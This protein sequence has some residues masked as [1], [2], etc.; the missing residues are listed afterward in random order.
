MGSPT[1]TMGNDVVDT[2]YV[3]DRGG[4]PISE[5]VDGAVAASHR[6]EHVGARH[7]LLRRPAG[8]A[9]HVHV[10]D[11]AHLGGGAPGELDEVRFVVI[12]DNATAKA[13]L[14]YY[15]VSLAKELATAGALGARGGRH[16]S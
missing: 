8:G 1:A 3:R 10:L 5:E 16:V 15:T 6:L 11:E 12:P 7:H 2:F 4:A 13:A 9:P 14:N